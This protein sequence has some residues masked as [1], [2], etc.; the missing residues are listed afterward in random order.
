MSIVARSRFKDSS[1]V[2]ASVIHFKSLE[3]GNLFIIIPRWVRIPPLAFN[4]EKKWI[5]LL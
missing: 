3:V 1:R 5:M 4:K 2:S